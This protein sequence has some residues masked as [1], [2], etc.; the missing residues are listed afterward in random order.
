MEWVV[1]SHASVSK[2]FRAVKLYLI[3]TSGKHKGMPILVKQD[4]FLMG[5][6]EVCQLRTRL[7]GMGAQHCAIVTRER[8][9]SA[10]DLG[11]GEAT[12]LNGEL[13]PPEEEWPL[14]AGDL[15]VV[16]PLEFLV[17]FHEKQLSQRDA[18]EWAFRCLE[19]SSEF[20]ALLEDE[21]DISGPDHQFTTTS[22]AASAILDKLQAMRGVV[23][24]RLRVGLR[25]GVTLVRFNDVYLVEP[26]EVALIKKELFATLSRPNLRVLLD[27]KNVRKMSSVAAEMIHDLHRHLQLKGCTL[28]LCRLRSELQPILKT[29]NIPLPQ[30][31]DKSS[32][33]AAKW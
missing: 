18:E 14:H 33:L 6:A 29:L 22:E 23:K 25:S 9:V 5:T 10:R 30:F 13:L 24:G 1:A 15:L 31:R 26:A 7:P 4:L 12:I 20:D 28:A 16:G 32:A 19:E 8:K 11:S 21:D 2:R 17:Q 27:F 3:V